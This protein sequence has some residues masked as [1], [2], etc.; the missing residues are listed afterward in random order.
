MPVRT[1]AQSVLGFYVRSTYERDLNLA[2]RPN[3]KRE[4]EA[5]RR[6]R[7]VGDSETVSHTTQNGGGEES[8]NLATLYVRVKFNLKRNNIQHFL[9]ESRQQILPSSLEL[10]HVVLSVALRAGH[11]L[12]SA[13]PV[14][15]LCLVLFS[16]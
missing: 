6:E 13:P 14:M 15:W 16:Y 2:D 12:A 3:E 5:V 7:E 11:R 4:A 9:F 10:L 8:E 1:R